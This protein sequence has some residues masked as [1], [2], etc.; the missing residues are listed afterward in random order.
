MSSQWLPGA[1]RGKHDQLSPV[2][3]LGIR[4]GKMELP[5]HCILWRQL[6]RRNMVTQ[7]SACQTYEQ[8]A[9]SSSRRPGVRAIVMALCCFLRQETKCNY[10]MS[11]ST[12][13]R[14]PLLFCFQHAI[15]H[16]HK[17]WPIS[18]SFV[19][20][21]RGR[22]F[23]Y[24]GEESGLNREEPFKKKCVNPPPLS[25]PN[26]FICPTPLEAAISW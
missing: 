23:F 18:Y 6:F 22:S 25:F 1:A 16:Y 4:P 21:V 5:Y 10:T 9:R 20:K 12:V 8:E 17:R 26:I 2:L 13:S 24:K 11:L 14:G 15:N 7:W 19:L 3:W